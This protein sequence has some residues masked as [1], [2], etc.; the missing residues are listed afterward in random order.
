L[1]G[2]YT[3]PYL[4]SVTYPAGQTVAGHQAQVAAAFDAVAAKVPAVRVLDEANTGDAAFRTKDGRTSY[5][6]V[7]YHFNPSPP[8]QLPTQQL[9]A[10][11]EEQQ[12]HQAET[13]LAVCEDGR[14]R[15]QARTGPGHRP[16]VLV[17]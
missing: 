3:A 14:R 17:A 12:R 6:M 4:L 16:Q 1:G 2:G 7:F 5:A 15:R 13:P 9:R 11:L 10:A 8:A